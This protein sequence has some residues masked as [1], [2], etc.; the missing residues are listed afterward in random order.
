MVEHRMWINVP[1]KFI[2]IR[3]LP[4][5]LGILLF[6][7]FTL[8]HAQEDVNTVGSQ[9]N[10]F[11]RLTTKP[12][13]TQIFTPF[14]GYEEE[15]LCA[16]DQYPATAAAEVETDIIPQTD[17]TLTIKS[18]TPI[19]STPIATATNTSMPY[20][21]NTSTSIPF[22]TGTLRPTNTPPPDI[23]VRFQR[24]TYSIAGQL[25]GVRV[26]TFDADDDVIDDHDQ[27][28]Y[29]D[30]LGSVVAVGWWGNDNYIMG[31][32][33]RYEPF[34]GYRGTIP[35]ETNPSIT[36][37][38]FTGHKENR[39]IGL[40][41][42]NARYF[43]PYIYRYLSPDSIVPDPANPQS[44]NRYSYVRNAP[45]NYT[46]PSGHD[47]CGSAGTVCN[48]E[49]PSIYKILSDWRTSGATENP[50]RTGTL[51]APIYLEGALLGKMYVM[52]P[53]IGRCLSA[54]R[55]DRVVPAGTPTGANLLLSLGS[56]PV[57]RPD[58]PAARPPF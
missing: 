10:T 57:T 3:I 28:L 9:P 42:M 50:N 37:R 38:G 19:S 35:D 6:P 55:D 15:L 17:G 11:E 30:H 7:G 8:I 46:D 49:L 43:M 4:F 25:V 40:T 44:L 33:I 48:D 16:E 26:A 51:V 5:I 20:V 2:S 52:P 53:V 18:P 22:A 45:I 29:T 41:Y 58:D 14:P 1:G 12:C 32:V 31:D 47:R 36:D 23:V 27:K 39:D 56:N 21:T 13:G 34:G 24:T 54:R